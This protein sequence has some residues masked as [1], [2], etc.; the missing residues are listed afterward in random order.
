MGKESRERTAPVSGKRLPSLYLLSHGDRP[1]RGSSRRARRGVPHALGDTRGRGYRTVPARPAPSSLPAVLALAAALVLLVQPDTTFRPE[2]AAAIADTA[3]VDATE[4]ETAEEVAT[5]VATDISRFRVRPIFSP[6]ALYSGSKGFGLSGGVAVDDVLAR[7]DHVQVEAR[8]SQRL[9]GGLVEYLTGEPGTDR[10]VGV[11]GGAAWTTSRSRFAGH[12]PRSALDGD[13]F[14]DRVSA[15][16]EAR[17]A[18][19][20]GGRDGVAFQPTA[21]LR[22]D[23]LRDLIEP[24]DGAFQSVLPADLARL[25]D[26]RDQARYGG[27]LALSVIRDTRD[28]PAMTRRGT[29][30]ESELARFQS[31]DGSGLGFWRVRATALTF[32]PA[33]FRV[34]FF[35]ERGAIFLRATGVVTRQDGAGPLPWYY[36]PDLEEDLLVGYPR[37][38]FTGR[39][40]LS[41]GIG[42]RGVIGQAVGAFLAEGVAIGMI[43][44]GYDDVFSEF[45]PRVQFRRRSAEAG[46]N[47]PLQPSVGIGL[48]IHFI[49][50]ERPLIGTLVGL[51]PG[52]FTLAS[53]RLVYGLGTYRPRLR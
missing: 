37:S 6:G 2:V 47:V 25:N 12:G 19:A 15:E 41:L 42:V 4:A 45:T 11:F 1:A 53:V 43:G 27:E 21:R 17:L 3:A 30:A 46:E 5:E 29:Y 31:F 35:P 49:D 34:P 26:L 39:D 28:I 14:I 40:G 38:E 23:R 10:L 22:Y 7:G 33:L 16:G 24:D 44:A 36:L 9:Q 48:N 20:P 13:L 8:L 52:G 32:R 18:W 50:R 51:G